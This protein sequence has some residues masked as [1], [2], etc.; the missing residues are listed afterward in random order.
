MAGMIGSNSRRGGAMGNFSEISSRAT[1]RVASVA[2]V[3]P[4]SDS[5]SS[6][7][8]AKVLETRSFRPKRRS[9]SNGGFQRLA[10]DEQRPNQRGDDARR[11]RSR[12]PAPERHVQGLVFIDRES[13]RRPTSRVA[14]QHQPS[15]LTNRCRVIRRLARRTCFC[16]SSMIAPLGKMTGGFGIRPPGYYISPTGLLY[17]AHRVIIYGSSD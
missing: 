16:S 9:I 15:T 10:A 6:G 17:F 5:K 11:N 7:G 2:T 4:A 8:M 12:A 14:N 1:R 13:A 3:W